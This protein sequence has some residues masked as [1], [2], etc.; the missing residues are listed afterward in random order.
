[1][2]A[3]IAQRDDA[4]S[5]ISFEVF[6]E[7]LI[8]SL[9]TLLPEVRVVAREDGIRFG[10]G[11]ATTEVTL[12]RAS[13]VTIVFRHG[14]ERVLAGSVPLSPKGLNDLAA[15]LVGFFCGA[16]L[17]TLALFPHSGPVRAPQVRRRRRGPYDAPLIP[18]PFGPPLKDF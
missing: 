3:S 6:Q 4:A 5:C 18:L 9:A 13:A 1:M 7:E 2:R 16:S 15:D 14:L 8:G 11:S 17:T 12:Q 10:R